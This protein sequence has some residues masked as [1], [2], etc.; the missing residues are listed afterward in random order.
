MIDGNE[1]VHVTLGDARADEIR[2]A[3]HRLGHAGRVIGLRTDLLVGP[4]NPPDPDTR[5]SWMKS[6]LHCE[7][8]AEDFE[9]EEPLVEATSPGIH[10]VYW[11]CMASTYERAS[12]I[13]FAFRMAG[14]RFDIV[15]ATGLA[16]AT[17]RGPGTLWSLGQMTAGDIVAS[18][19]YGLRRPVTPAE[20]AEATALWSRLREEDAPL[21]ILRN[22]Q[23]VSAPLDHFDNFIAS[24]A[25]PDWEIAAKLV[26][27][28]MEGLFHDPAQPGH[29]P[30]GLV[31]LGRI[32]ALSGSGVLDV[33]GTGPGMRDYTVRKSQWSVR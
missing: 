16:F 12:F 17:P 26:G 29:S 6:I 11:V 33:K 8:D 13:Q 24:Q 18:G 25:M 15:D 28:A 21:R 1:F 5:R 2:E 4:I 22:G 9:L 14:R 7:P 32:L 27:R 3:L 31:L 10:P 30:S 19:L 20:I 23:L